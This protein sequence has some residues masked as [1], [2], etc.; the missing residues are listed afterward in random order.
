MKYDGGSIAYGLF[1]A[2]S[3]VMLLIFHANWNLQPSI[4]DAK[5]FGLEYFIGVATGLPLA[6]FISVFLVAQRRFGQGDK[7]WLGKFQYIV[8]LPSLVLGLNISLGI[9]AFSVLMA[10][11]Y[12]NN[13][14]GILVFAIISALSLGLNMA[15][16]EP[17]RPSRGDA[18][19]IKKLEIEHDGLKSLLGLLVTI[20][21]AFAIS[22]IVTVMFSG[23]APESDEKLRMRDLALLHVVISTF[24]GILGLWYGIVAPI[25]GRMYSIR[26][27]L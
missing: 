23:S 24:W 15:L 7:K 16:Q 5:K 21:V 1:S 2:I 17:V 4:D 20:F 11:S 9:A 8:F 6:L 12:W 25:L 19:R 27:N 22:G 26:A 10:A 14:V 18:G 3:L 13:L